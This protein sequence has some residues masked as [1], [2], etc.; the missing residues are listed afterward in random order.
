MSPKKRAGQFHIRLQPQHGGA[1]T[2]WCVVGSTPTAVPSWQLDRL[3]QALSFW[4]GWRVELVLPVEV[5][6]VAWFSWWDGALTDIRP[7]HLRVR[8]SARPP[9]ATGHGDG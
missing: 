8:F 5:E 3:M 7:E 6:T 2:Q 4:S 1:F 9:K